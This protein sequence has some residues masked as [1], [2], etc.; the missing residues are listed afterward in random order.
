MNTL[1]SIFFFILWRLAVHLSNEMDKRRIDDLN[2]ES[3]LSGKILFTTSDR[4]A[5]D[6]SFCYSF[7][8]CSLF[9]PTVSLFRLR[10]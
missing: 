6:F 9:R 10:L 4:D 5:V 8:G 2:V 1:S 3:L 7:S